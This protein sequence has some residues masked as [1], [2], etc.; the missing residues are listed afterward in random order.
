MILYAA[1]DQGK[2]SK[3]YQIHLLKGR[4]YQINLNWNSLKNLNPVMNLL[5]R[6]KYFTS[7]AYYK[8]WPRIKIWSINIQ[9]NWFEIYEISC[10]EGEW[11]SWFND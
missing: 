7:L 5:S 6:I 10:P 9:I 4:F 2:I 3:L 8:E 11:S 1:K